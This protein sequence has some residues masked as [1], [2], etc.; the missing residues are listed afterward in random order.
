M[1]SVILFVS[2]FA[3]LTVACGETDQ[4]PTD[5]QPTGATTQQPTMPESGEPASGKLAFSSCIDA[6][7][8]G[9]GPCDIYIGEAD[10][11]G[12]THVVDGGWP[13]WSPDG[14]RFAFLMDDGQLAVARADGSGL[15]RLADS[16]DRI[17]PPSWSPDGSRIVFVRG[18]DYLGVVAAD[19]SAPAAYIEN[20]AFEYYFITPAWSPDGA[21]IVLQLTTQTPFDTE[22]YVI[23]PDFSGLTRLTDMEQ[24]PS[25]PAWS[26]DGSRIAFAAEGIYVMNADGSGLTKLTDSPA[27][28]DTYPI[29]SPDGARI[30]FSSCAETCGVSVVNSDGSGLANITDVTVASTRPVWPAWSPDGSRIA[31]SSCETAGEATF[32]CSISVVNADGSGLTRF[33]APASGFVSIVAWSPDAP[34]GEETSQ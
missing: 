1:R 14:S 10:G 13:V 22:V 25:S 29:W 5:A 24:T 11:S 9:H 2:V 27:A 32:S 34:S 7:G 31:F 30:A 23:N 19:G 6:D 21:R 15:L 17:S 8:E 18:Q 4:A 16:G 20:P 28:R 33:E 12:F 3:A 26:P